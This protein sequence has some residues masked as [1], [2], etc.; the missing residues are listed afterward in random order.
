MSG[1]Q[2][3]EHAGAAGARRLL[4]THVP[5]WFDGSEL[6]AEAREVFAG[7]VEL[8]VAGRGYEV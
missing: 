8:V 2:A 6:L 1:R 4:L 7:P 5:V 3:G